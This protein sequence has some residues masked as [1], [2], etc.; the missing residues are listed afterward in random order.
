[1][2]RLSSCVRY[3]VGWLATTQYR[4]PARRMGTTH[5]GHR[6]EVGI[7]PTLGC[8]L[9]NN[10][11]IIV[12]AFWFGH[13]FPQAPLWALKDEPFKL[14]VGLFYGLKCCAR[15][16][17]HSAQVFRHEGTRHAAVLKLSCKYVNEALCASRNH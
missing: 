1:M 15:I 13:C 14:L 17:V 12:Q 11:G 16:H 5:N 10:T 2:S 6:D 4:V 8:K 7:V 3:A 9:S